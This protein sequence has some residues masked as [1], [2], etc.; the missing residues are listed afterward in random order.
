MVKTVLINK[1]SVYIN[2]SSEKN[3]ISNDLIDL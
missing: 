1:W 3:E 2:K